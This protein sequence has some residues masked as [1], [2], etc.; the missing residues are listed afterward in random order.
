L[1]TQTKRIG[2]KKSIHSDH[3]FR[4]AKLCDHEIQLS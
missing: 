4:M 3:G 1:T 2:K